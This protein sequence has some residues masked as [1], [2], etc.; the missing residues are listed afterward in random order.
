MSGTSRRTFLLGTAGSLALASFRSS[1]KADANSVVRHAVI[2]CR[3]RG[4]DHIKGFEGEADSEVVALCDID[5]TVLGMQASRLEKSTK[6]KIKRYTD[7]RKLLDDKEIDT[8]SIATPN[9]WHALMAAWGMRAGKD[10]YVE[11][12]CTH[13]VSEGRRL[14]DIA[15]KTKRICQHGTQGRSSSAV[16][17]AVDFLREG[18]IGPVHTSK[19]LCYKWRPTIGIKNDEPVPKGVDYDLWLGPAPVH[20]FNRNRFHYNWHWFWDYGN[21]D[22][23]NQGV[24]QMDIAR[25]FIGKEGLP[26]KVNSSGGRFGYKDQGETPNTC[27]ATFDYGDAMLVFEVRGLPTNDEKGVKVGNIAYGAKGFLAMEGYGSW[28]AYEGPAGK[29]IETSKGY[30][31]KHGAKRGGGHYANFLKAVRSRRTEDLHAPIREGHLSSAL[32]HL[33]NISYR[34]GRSAIFDPESETF[35]DDQKANAFLTRNYRAPYEFPSSV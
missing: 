19:G 2:G 14:I 21:G 29:V 24:H 20:A 10:V 3:G 33:A 28:T 17:A 18:G 9:H 32:C 6:R 31:E 7:I 16:A 12:P 27:I 25:W 23:G 22:I 11:K 30:I 13:N 8:I 34:L 35:L 5:S 1:A 15:D 26:T 4:D